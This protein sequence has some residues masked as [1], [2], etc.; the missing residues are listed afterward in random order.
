MEQDAINKYFIIKTFFLIKSKR[1]RADYFDSK[2]VKQNGIFACS[3]CNSKNT[4]TNPMP[5]CRESENI[6]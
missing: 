6:V 4:V 2:G 5:A 1:V 3:E